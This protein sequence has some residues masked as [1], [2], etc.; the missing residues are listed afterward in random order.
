[1]RNSTEFL[2]GYLNTKECL[3][4]S[5]LK[6]HQQQ[7]Y[8]KLLFTKKCMS[9]CG[10]LTTEECW[11]NSDKYTSDSYISTEYGH[12]NTTNCLLANTLKIYHPQF[13]LIPERDVAPMFISCSSQTSMTGVPKA[14]V[15]IILSVG[16]WI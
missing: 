1:M 11:S 8:L 10:Y 9:L 14:V 16:W 2:Y 15:C 12:L 4:S 7:L 13:Y 5:V 3:S 6:I